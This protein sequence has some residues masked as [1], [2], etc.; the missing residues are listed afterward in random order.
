MFQMIGETMENKF[1]K[2]MERTRFADEKRREGSGSQKRSRMPEI[3]VGEEFDVTIEKLGHK[4]DGI[5]KI[6]NY[7]VF[8]KNTESGEDVK[9]KIKHVKDTIAFAE[10]LN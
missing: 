2:R 6:N 3:H 4:G 9:I 7:M 10:R 8:V 5:V 1:M